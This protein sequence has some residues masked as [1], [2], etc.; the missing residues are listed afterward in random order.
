MFLPICYSAYQ[1]SE[2]YIDIWHYRKTQIKVSYFIILRWHFPVPIQNGF[3]A[4]IIQTDDFE[5]MLNEGGKIMIHRAVSVSSPASPKI[6]S[7]GTE[8]E[9]NPTPILR[10]IIIIIIH[11]HPKSRQRQELH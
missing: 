9:E 6:Q 3:R 11:L 7:I 10:I 1:K 5:K 4:I 8:L 2:L